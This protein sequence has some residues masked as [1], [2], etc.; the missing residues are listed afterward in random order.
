MDWQAIGAIGEV[1]GAVGVILTLGYLANQIKHTREATLQATRH[2]GSTR[3]AEL[4]DTLVS[5]PDTSRL[6]L[7]GIASDPSL[8]PHD[9]F[10]FRTYLL[11]QALFWQDQWEQGQEGLLSQGFLES[12]QANMRGIMGTPAWQAWF[13]VRK[14]WLGSDFRAFLESELEHVTQYKPAGVEPPQ[15]D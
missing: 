5:N 10:R 1:L 8:E 4:L 3:G 7:R 6:F 12:L 2:A 14:H 13:E 11:Q 15:T 9:L